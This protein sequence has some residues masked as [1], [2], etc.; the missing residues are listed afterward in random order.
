MRHRGKRRP[1][2]GNRHCSACRHYWLFSS[3]EGDFTGTI[4]GNRHYLTSTIKEELFSAKR[5]SEGGGF[6][7]PA[8]RNAA[9]VLQCAF[10][11]TL[12]TVELSVR[13][14]VAVFIFLSNHFWPQ[15]IKKNRGTLYRSMCLNRH[16]RG[17]PHL[18]SASGV[19]R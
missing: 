13:H 7:T 15:R 6:V 12:K 3:A 5:F 16:C 1:Y 11:C 2:S 14:M 18:Y 17:T 4:V 8:R 9:F 10:F 19:F